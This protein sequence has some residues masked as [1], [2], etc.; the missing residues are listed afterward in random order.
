MIEQCRLDQR[1]VTAPIVGATKL[2]HNLED[3]V[4][5]TQLKLSPDGNTVVCCCPRGVHTPL[6]RTRTYPEICP[7]VISG[8]PDFGLTKAF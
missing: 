5:A 4:A 7:H 3:A 8:P 1:A 2:T 6:E